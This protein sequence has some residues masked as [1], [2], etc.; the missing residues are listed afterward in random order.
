MGNSHS[1]PE[2]GEF[3]DVNIMSAPRT[4]TLRPIL[5]PIPLQ[6]HSGGPREPQRVE[7]VIDTDDEMPYVQSDSDD[8]DDDDEN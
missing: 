2:E 4:E 1:W 5:G 7:P 3:R 8:D 6:F